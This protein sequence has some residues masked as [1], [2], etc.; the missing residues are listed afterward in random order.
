MIKNIFYILIIFTIISCGQE[1]NRTEE[2]IAA[3]IN[4][5]LN[6]TLTDV[7]TEF[8]QKLHDILNEVYYFR[9]LSLDRIIRS[10]VVEL[11]AT[12]S[13]ISIEKY[14]EENIDV[15][16]TKKNLEKFIIDRRLMTGVPSIKNNTLTSEQ[17]NEKG[18]NPRFKQIYYDSLYEKLT[19]SLKNIYKIEVNLKPPIHP[20]T[21]MSDV[22]AYFRGNLNSNVTFWE[23]SDLECSVCRKTTPIYLELYEKYKDKIR[24]AYV[25]YSSGVN[26]SMLL[27]EYANENN[28]FWEFHD[29]IVSS[30]DNIYQDDY[31]NELL[32]LG[33]NLNSYEEIVIDS[34]SINIMNE[35]IELLNSKRFYGTPSVLINGRLIDPFDIEQ[36]EKRI[37]DELK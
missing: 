10:K 20:Y 34:N 12:E 29:A 23:V 37:N 31:F 24:F 5:T 26:T 11:A 33:L 35:N 13:M 25:P 2:R 14:L 8:S 32:A 4:D 27:G 18:E 7:D 9:K 28:L 30:N 21:D 19:D 6:I 3:T 36:I 1:N 16:L 17:Y 15:F 22:K